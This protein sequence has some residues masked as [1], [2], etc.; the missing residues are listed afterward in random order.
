MTI[1][2]KPHTL[3]T[4][5]E[6]WL[7]LYL[8]LSVCI[9]CLWGNIDT[10]KLAFPAGAVIGGAAV[11]LLYVLYREKGQSDWVRRLRSPRMSCWL[12]ALVAGWCVVGGSLPSASS[13]PTSWPFVALLIALL[14]HLSLVI[15]HR[16]HHFSFRRDGAFMSLHAGLWLALFSGVA[17]AGDTMEVKA[18]VGR[19]DETIMAVGKDG[20]IHPL[21]Y[22]LQLQDF[23]IEINEADGSPTQYT[24]R[25]LMDGQPVRVSVN[26]P[27]QV[28]LAEDIYLTNFEALS[29]AGVVSHCVLTIVHQPWKYPMLMGI[30]LLMA[31][32]AWYL[33]RLGTSSHHS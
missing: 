4:A 29:G 15:I 32:V 19:E 11:A 12:L 16:L 1:M 30:L 14:A 21:G 17:G 23:S 3:L 20:R 2:T 33:K 18:I 24:A 7:I 31:G 27:L 9:Q 8:L 22:S 28:N 13:F 6:L 25:M 26:S 10:E 5:P